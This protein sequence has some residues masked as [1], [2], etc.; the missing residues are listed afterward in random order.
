MR[1]TMEVAGLTG[2]AFLYWITFA[3]LNGP[4]RLPKRIPTHFDFSGHPN[5]WG[6]SE[7]LWLLPMIGT[8]LYLLMTALA[9]IRFR[10]YNLPVR[11]TDANLPFIHTRTAEMVAWIKCEV[12]GLFAFIQWSIIQGAKVGEFH[13]SP[14]MIPIFIAMVFGTVGLY[15]GVIIRGART[16][17]ERSDSLDRVQR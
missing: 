15:L 9:S 7:M 6:S 13:L 3:A 4:D 10:R 11:L 1:K 17:A 2:L 8:G 5:A 14:V 16:R 12:L